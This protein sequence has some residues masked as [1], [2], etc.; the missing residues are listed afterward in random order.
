MRTVT[1]TCTHRLSPTE[2]T[3]PPRTRDLR[4]RGGRSPL[5]WLGAAAFLF[6]R[7]A[8][9]RHRLARFPAGL[10]LPGLLHRGLGLPC[11]I[12]DE[13][14]LSAA[15][16]VDRTPVAKPPHRKDLGRSAAFAVLVLRTVPT[17]LTGNPLG[18]VLT[19]GTMHVAAVVH[20][21]EGGATAHAAAEGDARVRRPRQQRP[22]SRPCSRVA[23]HRRISFLSLVRRRTRRHVRR[24]G[25]RCSPAR[26][27]KPQLGKRPDRDDSASS[28]D[29]RVTRAG[30]FWAAGLVACV[31]G[32]HHPHS[33]RR[34]PAR[35]RFGTLSPHQCARR[36]LEAQSDVTA[37]RQVRRD[38]AGV[39]PR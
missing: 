14:R 38:R 39:R 1:F 4:Q 2:P 15:A 32:H 37:G 11:H 3:P 7:G 24:Y 27:G 9:R 35:S 8:V 18:A 33:D 34:R 17:A 20:Q 23:A 6:L 26:G 5:L 13:V 29:V 25:H 31:N 12:P 30:D 10:V 36:E 22:G 21:N 16:P 28:D 19:H